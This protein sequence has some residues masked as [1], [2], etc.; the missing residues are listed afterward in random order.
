[1]WWCWFSIQL[2]VWSCVRLYCVYIY[3]CV[4]LMV[5]G[6]CEYWLILCVCDLCDDECAHCD[7]DG[8][9]SHVC[10]CLCVVCCVVS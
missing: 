3:V 8:V 1:M 10:L 6:V 7:V 9:Q 5:D 2:C 4:M